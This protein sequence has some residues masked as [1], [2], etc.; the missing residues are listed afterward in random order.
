MTGPGGRPVAALTVEQLW[1]P[2]PGGSGRYVLE[3]SRALL[4]RADVHPVG[5]AA[6]HGGPPPAAWV[7]DDRLPVVES[8]LPR[9]ALYE[10][11]RRTRRPRTWRAIRDLDVVHATTWAV[12]PAGPPLVVTVHD[13][14]FRRDPGHFTPHGVAYFE[15]ALSLVQREA[16]AVVAVSRTTADDAIAA[17]VDASRVHVVPH[18]VAVPPATADDVAKFRAAHGLTRPYVLW[19]GT[20][21]PR[22][23]LG[24]LLRA[25]AALAASPDAG[26]DLVLVGPA[27]WGDADAELSARVAELP[28]GRVHRLGA[29]DT[30]T[31]HRAYAGA[32]AFAFP[33]LWEGFG[34]PVL[35]A[36]AHGVPVVTSSGTSMAEVAG[37]AALL[38]DPRDEAALAAALRRAAGDEHDDLAAA[39]LAVAARHSW[40]RTAADTLGVYAWAAGHPR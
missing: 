3:L 14:A 26:L 5:L 40:D 16:A 37:D 30:T 8:R 31:L 39:S 33:S 35:E 10:A 28:P 20:V 11:W 24:T 12:P 32:R 29:V 34:L 18:G 17:G 9:T 6:R 15:R 38:V 13:L 22:K 19:T 36:M 7:P 2:V 23:N 4:D 1:Q 25:F 27:G 21:E